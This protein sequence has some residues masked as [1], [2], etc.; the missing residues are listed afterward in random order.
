MYPV[1]QDVIDAEFRDLEVSFD[2]VTDHDPVRRYIEREEWEKL[3]ESERNQ[4]ALDR[5]IE[6]RKKSKW[7]IGRDYEL[8]CGYCYEKKGFLVDYFGSYNGLDDLGRDLIIS[9]GDDIRIVQ[10]KYWSKFKT[11]HEKHIFQL[12]GSMYQYRKQMLKDKKEKYIQHMQN[13]RKRLEGIK[14]QKEI[15]MIKSGKYEIIKDVTKIKKWKRKAR[16]M[17]QKLPPE[18]FYENTK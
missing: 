4:R 12:F 9:K 5:Y 18:I 1:L 3:S 11:I 14:R 16:Q 7:Q 2:Q 13:E 6:S 17:L 8:Y 15:N 10:C